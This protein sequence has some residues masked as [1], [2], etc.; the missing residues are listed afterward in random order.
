M[1]GTWHG[2]SIAHA[3]PDAIAGKPTSTRI[4]D[5]V[6]KAYGV[7]PSVLLS[8]KRIAVVA[9]ARQTAMLLLRECGGRTWE[10]VA[11]T[12][13]RSNHTT[14]MY[15]ARQAQHRIDNGYDPMASELLA[16]FQGECAMIV[17][18]AGET[19][20]AP[21]PARTAA[22][23]DVI[24]RAKLVLLAHS[25]ENHERPEMRLA[26]KQLVDTVAANGGLP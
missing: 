17:G 11:I 5:E 24:L 1:I 10:Q 16:S 12:L 22:T 4:I 13:R 21:Q 14:A 2:S 20:P 8:S 25:W 6:C 23:V 9:Q 18:D 19:L 15:G 7:L 26:A 3:R